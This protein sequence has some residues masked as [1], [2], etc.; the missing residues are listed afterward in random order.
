MRSTEL[1]FIWQS[2]CVRLSHVRLSVKVK[3]YT[4]TSPAT[5]LLMCPW[6]ANTATDKAVPP[7]TSPP[8]N[9]MRKVSH[10][11]LIQRCKWQRCIRSIRSKHTSKRRFSSRK[12]RM[13]GRPWRVSE[14]RTNT[15]DLWTLSRRLVSRETLRYWREK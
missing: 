7:A 13:T 6:L 15:G 12:A 9:C 2:A 5:E 8:R 3:L 1:R 10:R 11:L 4:R 14:K